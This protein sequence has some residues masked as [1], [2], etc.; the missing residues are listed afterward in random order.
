MKKIML[1]ASALMAITLLAFGSLQA[2]EDDEQIN[3]G[4]WSATVRND[5]AYIQFGSLHWS[6]GANFDLSELGPL[7][8]GQTGTFTVKREPGSVTF[9]GS[10]AAG[11]GHGTYVFT[12]NA[13]F[14]T[15]L[16]QEG[17]KELPDH[18]VLHL[19]FTNINREYFSYMKTN[20]YTG[21]TI[22][23]LKDLAYQ[24][25]NQQVLV[26]YVDLSKQQGW[27]KLSLEDVVEMREH[28]ATPSFIRRF[29]DMGYKD[30]SVSKAV[31]LVD[32]GV[33]PDFITEMKKF[34]AKDL[35][36]DEAIELRDHGVSAEYIHSLQ[37]L[38][39]TNITPERATELV[40]HGVSVEFIRGFQE[41]GYKEVSLDRA[42]EL[43]DHGV[44]PDFVKKI[45]DLGFADISLEKA[46]ELRDHGVDAAFI[47]RMQDKGL[48]GLSL[49]QYQRM[50]DAG[51]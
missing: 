36:L 11:Q 32:H 6:S 10:F 27:G 34:G 4:V 8:E 50:R 40:D 48:K 24:N 22:D 51:M 42:R 37:E 49:D 26:G 1:R 39:Y 31:E 28:G 21:I 15:F 5:K 30:I 20:G 23:E 12:P 41:I 25:I 16:T 38:G 44:N 9:N 7:P 33:K 2:Q 3:P 46:V 18:L 19:F 13:D 45:K 43:R 35:T 29:L 14:K 17:F 47:K